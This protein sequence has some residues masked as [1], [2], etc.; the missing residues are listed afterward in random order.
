[1]AAFAEAEKQGKQGRADEYPM[2][3]LHLDD[4]RSCDHPHDE[5]KRNGKHIEDHR[6][7]ESNGVKKVHEPVCSNNQREGFAQRAPACDRRAEQNQH[8]G[9]R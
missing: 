9:Q 8:D 4:N 2:T 3:D 6:I 7:L 1:M 5:S